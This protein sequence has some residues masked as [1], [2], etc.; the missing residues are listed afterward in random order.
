MDLKPRPRESG[1]G[2]W[3]IQI[4]AEENVAWREEG[5]VRKI[6]S[7]AS[8]RAFGDTISRNSRVKKALAP[9]AGRRKENALL[10]LRAPRAMFH[11]WRVRTQT[12]PFSLLV[13]S[14]W[15]SRVTRNLVYVYYFFPRAS[16]AFCGS[17][18]FALCAPGLGILSR[19]A[20]RV[21]GC[22][23]NNFTHKSGKVIATTLVF[24]VTF[25]K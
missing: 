16:H 23:C 1:S 10:H 25:E 17:F 8:L 7:A 19:V 11:T 14:A 24:T 21:G 3:T 22:V 18:C 5:A 20:G 4:R 15:P 2:S 13:E 6:G 9:P 12:S